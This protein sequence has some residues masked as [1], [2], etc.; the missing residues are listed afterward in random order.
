MSFATTNTMV[1]N[2][3]TVEENRLSC[4]AVDMEGIPVHHSTEDTHVAY[5]QTWI[6]ASYSE[7][8]VGGIPMTIGWVW[9]RPSAT[10]LVLQ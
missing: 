3:R 6:R 10:R 1:V 9:L 2:N 5:R 4:F 8:S 7:K